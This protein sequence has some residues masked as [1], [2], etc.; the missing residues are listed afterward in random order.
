LNAWVIWFRVLELCYASTMAKQVKAFSER[1]L[2]RKLATK[3][4]ILSA[5]IFSESFF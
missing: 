3:V 2:S 1:Y 5:S 4:A